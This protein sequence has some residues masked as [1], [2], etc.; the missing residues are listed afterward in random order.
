MR[1]CERR[2]GNK[3]KQ[4]FK[5]AGLTAMPVGVMMLLSVSIILYETGGCGFMSTADLGH[6]NSQQARCTF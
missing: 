2:S 1:D 5:S 4:A 3:V 6:A